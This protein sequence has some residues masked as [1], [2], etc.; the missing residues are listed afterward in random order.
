MTIVSY[1][2]YAASAAAALVTLFAVQKQ[3]AAKKRTSL[4]PGPKGLPVLGNVLDFASDKAWLTFDK[5]FKQYGR[6]DGRTQ[7]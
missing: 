4:P 3:R 7:M 1:A 5:W 6:F 2:L